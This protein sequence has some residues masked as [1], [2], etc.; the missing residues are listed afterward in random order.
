V[1]DCRNISWWNVGNNI[2][3]LFS[4]VSLSAGTSGDFASSTYLTVFFLG[5]LSIWGILGT[6]RFYAMFWH[7]FGKEVITV[8][9]DSLTLRR[10]VLFLGRDHVYQARK[11]TGVRFT[12]LKKKTDGRW[13]TESLWRFGIARIAFDFD[14]KTYRFGDGLSETEAEQIIARIWHYLVS[15]TNVG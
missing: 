7:L 5:F 15:P 9:N 3:F 13:S 6:T 14:G 11:I 2:I 10:Q 4:E 8:S 12:P 1:G